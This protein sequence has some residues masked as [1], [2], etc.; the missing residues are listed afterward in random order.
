MKRV[1][2]I[3]TAAALLVSLATIMAWTNTARGAAPVLNPIPNIVISE[4]CVWDQSVS[5]S[6][7]DGD[8]LTFSKT[9]GPTYMTVTTTSPTTGNINLAP[10]FSDAGTFTATVTASDGILTDSKSFTISITNGDRA[11]VLNQPANM[12]VAE[13]ATANQVITGS[14]PDVCDRFLTFAK[15]SGPIFMTVTT[16]NATSGNIHL[17]PGASTLGTYSGTVTVSDGFLSDAKS[18]SI[19][20]TPCDA[21]PVLTQPANMIVAPGFT[22]DQMLTATDACGSSLAFQKVAGPAF[23]TVTTTTP[24]SGTASGNVHL[25]PTFAD[26]GTFSVTVRATDGTFSNDKS[27]SINVQG[28]DNPPALSQ[29]ANMTADEGTTADQ[30]LTA[31]DPDGNLLTFSKAAGP[32]FMLVTTTTPGAGTATGNVH[33]AP[34]FADQGAYSAAVRVSDGS[35]SDTK[36]FTITVVNHDACPVANPGGPYSGLVGIPV[37]F[38]GTGSSDADGDVITYAW[39]FG[40]GSTGVGVTPSHTYT[41][42]GLYTVTLAVTDP[43]PCSSSAST[44]ASILAACAATVVNGYDVIRLNSGRHEWFAFVQPAD[45][46]YANTDVVLS[47]FV[48]RYG[49]N[50]SP[51]DV[52]KTTLDSDNNKD[53][54]PDLRIS[55]SKGNLRTLF[56]GLPSG[57]NTVGVTIEASL[58]TGG[59]LRGTTQLDV[60]SSGSLG[61]LT[62]APNPFNPEATISFTTSRTGSGTVSLFDISG[63]QVRTLLDDPMLPAGIHEVMLDGRGSRGE[64]LPSGIYFVRVTS[65][66]GRFDRRVVLLK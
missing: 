56:A 27:F 32:I 63:H 14:D 54:I 64:L 1:P 55:F 26:I 5:G 34:G 65:S 45:G 18:F 58:V 38:D 20:V 28:P 10:G 25:A 36:S 46:C 47:S 3:S 50:Q 48:L 11:P 37:N 30:T 13:G 23:M 57:H 52:T 49:G 33:L 66:E 24:G 12:T 44:T 40:D 29:P 60:V 43:L 19:T 62:V 2:S 41:V 39:D 15:L 51:A 7:P 42:A 6:D 59:I 8:P 35:L 16:T 4:G 61:A 21:A 9:A 31:T 53:G 22:S 17:A